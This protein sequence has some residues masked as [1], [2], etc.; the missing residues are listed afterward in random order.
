MAAITP[1]TAVI[2]PATAVT[3]AETGSPGACAVC[4]G[5]GCKPGIRGCADSSSFLAVVSGPAR[6]PPT[7]AGA[8]ACG[9]VVVVVVTSGE[10]VVTCGGDVVVTGSGIAGE[11][12]PR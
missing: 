9:D 10:V 4:V 2:M 7:G 12:R 11:V 8:T 6:R 3:I 5:T 1:A